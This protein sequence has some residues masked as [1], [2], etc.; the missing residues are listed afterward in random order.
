MPKEFKKMLLVYLFFGIIAIIIF[1]ISMEGKFV[2]KKS[3]TEKNYNTTINFYILEDGRV[4]VEQ[5]IK[6]APMNY[7]T[8]FLYDAMRFDVAKHYENVENIEVYY[9]NEK[10]SNTENENGYFNYR[11]CTEYSAKIY[12]PGIAKHHNSLFNNIEVLLP[13]TS[14]DLKIV[15]EL[16]DYIVSYNDINFFEYNLE[17][18]HNIF[19]ND[20]KINIIMPKASEEFLVTT[21]LEFNHNSIIEILNPTT[22]QVSLSGLQDDTFHLEVLFDRQICESGSKNNIDRY[23]YLSNKAKND[24][25]E[26]FRLYF[27]MFLIVLF[28]AIILTCFRVMH[29]TYRFK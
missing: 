9:N 29:N 11:Y 22:K 21:N 19:D 15:Y 12:S 20:A 1:I 13:N 18:N 2:S 10:L 8:Y 24:K 23:D 14:Y 4:R 16:K 6:K 5:N 7:S 27:I 25:K 17:Y 3:L 28:L 26:R